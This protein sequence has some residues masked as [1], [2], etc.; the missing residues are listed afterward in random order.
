MKKTL[1]ATVR[2][3]SLNV[4]ALG[5]VSIVSGAGIGATDTPTQEAIVGQGAV[6]GEGYAVQAGRITA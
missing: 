1:R 5:A 6:V 3:L 4:A 2:I